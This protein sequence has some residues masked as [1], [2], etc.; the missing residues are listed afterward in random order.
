MITII[1]I[2]D[3]THVKIYR[4]IKGGMEEVLEYE[5][6]VN[7][8]EAKVVD[9][10]KIYKNITGEYNEEVYYKV[11]SDKRIALLLGEGDWHIGLIPST[12]GGFLGEEFIFAPGSWHG[13]YIYAFE[14]AEVTIYDAKG[15]LLKKIRLWQNGSTLIG[16]PKREVIRIV[17]TGRIAIFN[18][19][20]NG[21]QAM[22]SDQGRFKGR[23][24]AGAVRT[25][26]FITAYEPCQVKV[27][28]YTGKLVGTHTFTKEEVE[29]GK[30]FIIDNLS[31]LTAVP[32][33]VIAT[34]DVTVVTDSTGD[35]PIYRGNFFMYADSGE[36]LRIYTPGS[37]TIFTPYNCKL[38]I[39]GQPIDSTAN[40]YWRLTG[41]TTHIIKADKPI[42]VQVTH[43]HTITYVP[44]DKD[45]EVVLPPPSPSK[46]VPATGP[47][48]GLMYGGT[49]L[50][51][52]ILIA[53][54]II[55]LLATMYLKLFR[56]S[57]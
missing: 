31:Y 4:L 52:V 55:V 41:N 42:I 14:D 37:I 11:V 44:C 51:Y 35:W 36:E 29:E 53:I 7:R 45:A 12:E 20:H 17:S 25:A 39:D 43:S 16:L 1:G 40:Q 8:L 28:D 30:P 54:V 23:H 47:M 46:K 27:Y 32:M 24:L 9:L 38:W 48:P 13:V 10:T 34:G 50:Y 18:N 33:R 3:T 22:I 5:L 6:T 49:S 26:L 15:K 19:E 2:N 56:K 57:K 21:G